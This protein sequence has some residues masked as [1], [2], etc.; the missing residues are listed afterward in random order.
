MKL[1]K[2]HKTYEDKNAEEH[3][4]LCKEHHDRKTLTEEVNPIYR[5]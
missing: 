2:E 1:N 3:W 5:Y 4:A